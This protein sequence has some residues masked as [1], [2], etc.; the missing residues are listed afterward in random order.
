V[1]A[2]FYDQA[3]ERVSTL[4]GVEGAA[5]VDWLPA[6]GWGSVT[7]FTL[8]SGGE[9]QLAEL[10]IIGSGYFDTMGIPLLAGRPF[11]GRDRESSSRVVI[12]NESFA[13]AYF[14]GA[15]VGQSVRF[16]RGDT[17]FTA[18]IVGVIRDVREISRRLP[19]A[20]GVYAPKTQ[21]P[22]RN[23]ETRELVV[24]MAGDVEPPSVAMQT[25]LRDLEPDMPVAPLEP[26][27]EVT[28]VP[29]VRTQ[30]YASAVLVFAVVA[31]L[32]A[33]FGIYGVV[34]AIVV[35][36]SRQIG[37]RMALGA[38]SARVIADAARRGVLPTVVG[39]LAGVPLALGA[40]RLVRQQLFG[41][42]PTDIPTLAFVA[43]VMLSVAITAAVVPARRAAY[44]DPAISLREQSIG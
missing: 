28:S 26:L 17:P 8:L 42:Q 41:V 4:P 1:L 20:P 6:S 38:T 32:L 12:V 36:G 9:R 23:A 30:L 7:G 39:L 33:A 10:R 34:S 37:I 5:V 29:I 35:Q 14:G 16:D 21:E 11:D 27:A 31:V 22:W 13:R 19:P 43:A 18:E 25:A 15:A 2:G 24:R 40:G 3:V 44:V